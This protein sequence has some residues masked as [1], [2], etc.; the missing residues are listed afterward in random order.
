MAKKELTITEVA[1]MGGTAKN[2]KLSPEEK[3]AVGR[4][5]ALARWGKKKATPKP[6]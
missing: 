2:A 5:A 3:S 4:K 1:R 6:R